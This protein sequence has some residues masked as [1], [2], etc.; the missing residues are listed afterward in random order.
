MGNTLIL[1]LVV[2]VVIGILIVIN[3]CGKEEY[4]WTMGQI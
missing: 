4:G 2:A 3:S 1:I